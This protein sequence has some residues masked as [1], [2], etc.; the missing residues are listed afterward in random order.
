MISLPPG[1]Y[2]AKV[3]F[4]FAGFCYLQQG[5]CEGSDEIQGKHGEEGLGD[6]AHTLNGS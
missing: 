5:T 3:V 2:S 4:G 1:V 6:L